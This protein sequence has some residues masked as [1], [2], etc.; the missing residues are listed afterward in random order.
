MKVY[1]GPIAWSQTSPRPGSPTIEATH[2]DIGFANAYRMEL[3]KYLLTVAAALFA[4]T[5]TF[6]PTLEPVEWRWAMWWGWGGLA[7]SMLGGVVH[8]L[9]WDHYY[10][11]YRDFEYGL[12][13]DPDPERGKCEGRA[14][15][16]KVNIWRRYGMGAQ[17]AGFA[18]GVI[19]VGM[20]AAVNIDNVRRKDTDA[21]PVSLATR[22]AP[23]GTSSANGASTAAK[24]GAQP[25]AAPQPSPT[26][27]A[28]GKT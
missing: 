21:A 9:G 5:V 15:R 13:D 27:S 7:V 20:F 26:A 10:K 19:G 28:G 8:L 12:R 3:V 6:R 22:A 16:K 1:Y 2:R 14:K 11:S 4:F 18:V 23:S 25:T 24:I 17:Y